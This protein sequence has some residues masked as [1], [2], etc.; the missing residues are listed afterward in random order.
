MQL[1]S[2]QQL[3]KL[4]VRAQ[5]GDSAAFDALYRATA[6]VQMSQIC[7]YMGTS[8]GVEDLLQEVYLTLWKH[9]PEIQRPEALVAYLNRTTYHLCQNQRRL[10]GRRQAIAPQYALREDDLPPAEDP[11]AQK[12][13]EISLQVALKTLSPAQRRAVELRYFQGKTIREI[14][15]ETHQS[16][17]TVHRLLRAALEKLRLTVLPAVVP[18]LALPHTGALP[19]A[20]APRRPRPARRVGVGAA[21]TCA[22]AV[23]AVSLAAVPVEIAGVEVGAE[24]AREQTISVRVESS[25]PLRQLALTGPEGEAVALVR[26]GKHYRG[27]VTRNGLYL[28]TAVGVTGARAEETFSVEEVDREGPALV[29]C[30]QEGEYTWLVMEDPAGVASLVCGE[31]GAEYA[32]LRREGDAFAFSLPAGNH[33]IRAEDRLGNR[34]SGTVAVEER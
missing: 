14:C 11:A 18:V 9:L 26:D 5:Q 24:P 34:S 33:R 29:Q 25:L 4:L 27:T 23:A 31:E 12:D 28:L 16:A 21:V 20:V 10:Q 3:G 6:P 7:L 1:L 2:H 17:S 19:A 32:P 22:A 15:E 30:R 8:Q 13:W